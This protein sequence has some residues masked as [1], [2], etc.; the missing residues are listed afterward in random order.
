MNL[1]LDP[2]IPIR[3]TDG[4][5][6]HISPWQ[7]TEVN[8]PIVEIDAPRADFQGALYQF[9][10]GLLQ[11]VIAPSEDEEWQEHWEVPPSPE[12]LKEKFNQI[13]EVFE[14]EN[15]N[16]PAFLQDLRLKEG[17]RKPLAALLIESPGS[18]TLKENKDFFV[19]R[20]A[21]EHV[22]ESCTISALFTLQTNAPSGGS[23]HRVGLRGGGPLTTLIL[24]QT[25][26]STL[27]QKLWLNILPSDNE[28][29]PSTI[30]G[31]DPQV[32]P[33]VEDTRLSDKTGH[34]TTP[35]D[36]NL[37]QAYWG[38]P[39][40]I[41]LDQAEKT[42]KYCDICGQLALK[43]YRSF[44]TKNYG[45]NYEGPWQHP[46]TPYSYDLKNKKPPLSI[47]GQKGG[48]GYRHWLGLTLQNED[49]SK[50]AAFNVRNFNDL[51]NDYLDGDQQA[52]LWCFGY[53]MDNMKARCWYEQTFPLFIIKSEKKRG[54]IQTAVEEILEIAIEAVSTLKSQ[55]KAAWF[56]RP[57]DVK[58][59]LSA[60]DQ[61]FWEQTENVFYDLLF[62]LNKY[63]DAVKKIPPEIAEIWWKTV[64]KS[65][66]G[67]FDQWTLEANPEDLDLAAIMK[68]RKDLKNKI[69]KTKIFKNFKSRF[70]KRE[71][72]A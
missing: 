35:E 48:L 41:R 21:I 65:V 30:S 49:G 51:I 67:L 56:R 60:V 22:C 59:E 37:L 4:S 43:V 15:S 69:N 46:L 70:E 53:D 71:A 36:V 23:G 29:V 62:Q 25:Q 14:L 47:K 10:I 26:H 31:P 52:R 6:S 55:V 11:T 18:N 40:R 16:G 54:F 61:S 45:I 5:Q 34:S 64:T 1:L 58:G 68:S 66:F 50:Q 42:E 24:P 2:W 20:G 44:I 39:R 57:K 63:D 32:L 28:T 8:N 13:S 38:M 12:L 17:E 19:K 27:W 3:R 7:I 9:L 72:E 33:W